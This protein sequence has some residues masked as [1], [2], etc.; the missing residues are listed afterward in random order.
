MIPM[1]SQK[2]VKSKP[3]PVLDIGYRIQVEQPNVPNSFSKKG[4]TLRCLQQIRDYVAQHFPHWTTNDVCQQLIIPLTHRDQ[5][6]F[7]DFLKKYYPLDSF[8][9]TYDPNN[10]LI[11]ETIV[12]DFLQFFTLSHDDCYGEKA[13]VYVSHAWK[14][15]FVELVEAL[16]TFFDDNQSAKLTI[17]LHYKQREAFKR[18]LRDYYEETLDFFSHVDITQSETEVKLDKFR[19]VDAAG[20]LACGVDAVNKQITQ[21]LREWVT[22]SHDALISPAVG[23]SLIKGTI[24]ENQLASYQSANYSDAVN[25]DMEDALTEY[26]HIG[27]IYFD[28]GLLVEAE[29]MFRR[30]LNGREKLLGPYHLNTVNT[31]NN[32]AILLHN[33]DRQEEAE[34]MYRRAINGSLI[35]LG[36]DHPDTLSAMNSFGKLLYNMRKLEE[37]EDMCRR[38]VNGREK[39]LGPNDVKTIGSLGNLGKVLLAL[40]QYDEAETILLKVL[41]F[42]EK[43]Y[44]L[45]DSKTYE[46]VANL[47]SCYAAEGKLENAETMYRRGIAG[48]QYLNK[49]DHQEIIDLF[50]QLGKAIYSRSSFAMIG[51]NVNPNDIF[52]SVSRDDSTGF[53]NMKSRSSDPHFRVAEQG[54]N[55]FELLE[56]TRS[57]KQGDGGPRLIVPE[58]EPVRSASVQYDRD[59]VYDDTNQN[60]KRSLD[61]KGY[62]INPLVKND[63]LGD[64]IGIEMTQY[65]PFQNQTKHNIISHPKYNDE[66]QLND[67]G[68]SSFALRDSK[69]HFVEKTQQLREQLSK[70]EDYYGW[71]H[72]KSLK[73]AHQLASCLFVQGL[74]FDALEILNKV[75]LARIT[76]L[77]ENHIDSIDIIADL[78]KVYEII[79]E[80][81]DAKEAYS[82]VLQM[83][84]K[85]FG[86]THNRTIRSS[87]I[88]CDFLF[89]IGQVEQAEE[90][91]RNALNDSIAI[92]G[93]SHISTIQHAQRLALYLNG[94]NSSSVGL[95][96]RVG[97]VEQILHLILSGF[98]QHLGNAHITTLQH[99]LPLARLLQLKGLF[100]ESEDLYRRIMIGM[101]TIFLGGATN[102][103]NLIQVLSSIAQIMEI[104]G[105]CTDAATM[106]RRVLFYKQKRLGLNHNDTLQEMMVAGKLFQ[107]LGQF[108]E[109]EKMFRTV[110]KEREKVF[111]VSLNHPDVIEAIVALA[112]LLYSADLFVE[113]EELYNKA[114]E[115]ISAQYG[116]LHL[117]VLSL[118]VKL[119]S[120]YQSNNRWKDSVLLA[121]EILESHKTLYGDTHGIVLEDTD[122]L[123]ECLSRDKQ[124][125]DGRSYAIELQSNLL[126]VRIA[127]F[128][129]SIHPD[130]CSTKQR[131][132]DL[133]QSKAPEYNSTGSVANNDEVELLSLQVLSCQLQSLTDEHPDV[134][135]TVFMVGKMYRYIQNYGLAKEHYQRALA[136]RWKIYGVNHPDTLDVVQHLAELALLTDEFDEAEDMLRKTI[137][138]RGKLFS[139]P[140]GNVNERLLSHDSA[141][142]QNK[143][144]K[145][146]FGVANADN[147]NVGHGE[148]DDVTMRN[149]TILGDILMRSGGSNKVEEAIDLFRRV[150]RFREQRFGIHD[151]DTLKA[152]SKL[153]QLLVLSNNKSEAMQV[154]IKALAG[155]AKIFGDDSLEASDINHLIGKSF[156]KDECE[157]AE[158]YMRRAVSGREKHLGK[159]H[160]D[161]IESLFALGEIV[162]SLDRLDE[163]EVILRRVLKSCQKVFGNSHVLTLTVTH[164]LALVLQRE[165]LPEEAEEM[166]EKA[167]TG[168]ELVLGMEHADLMSTL[169]CFA[170]LLQAKG[171][172]IRAEELYQRALSVRRNLFG[173]ENL[174]TLATAYAY[175]TLLQNSSRLIEAEE[176]Y[177]MVVNGRVKLLGDEDPST[178]ISYNGLA[179]VLKANN[180]MIE[181]EVYYIKAVTG[182]EQ[183]LTIEHP[184]TLSSMHQLGLVY[185]ANEKSVEALAIFQRIFHIQEKELGQTH[186]DTIVTMRNIA[187]IRQK[188]GDLEKAEQ[189]YRHIITT[190]RNQLGADHADTINGVLQ[191]GYICRDRSNIIDAEKYF[192]RALGLRE[193]SLGA[194][195]PDTIAVS[196]DLAKLLM[197]TEQLVEAEALLRQTLSLFEDWYGQSDKRTLA[198]V[199]NLANTL[200]ASDSFPEAEECY[201]RVLV[202]YEEVFGIEHE[203]TLKIVSKLASMVY[204]LGR[205]DDS[206]LLFVRLA[207]GREKVLGALH[208]DTMHSVGLCI[209]IFQIRGKNDLAYDMYW[210]QLTAQQLVYGDQSLKTLSTMF[211]FGNLL[212]LM[213][214]HEQAEEQFRAALEGKENLFSK[215]GHM[216][217]GEELDLL[218]NITSLAQT[219][220]VLKKY[221]EAEILHRRYL[222][223]MLRM[224]AKSADQRQSVLRQSVMSEVSHAGLAEEGNEEILRTLHDLASVLATKGKYKES[225]E[226]F[227]R[228]I[229]GRQDFYGPNEEET[230]KSMVGLGVLYYK[231]YHPRRFQQG[232]DFLRQAS[233]LWGE[234]DDLVSCDIYHHLGSLLF[235]KSQQISNSDNSSLI[236]DAIQF[237]KKA[238][239]SRKSLLEENHDNTL[240]TMEMLA[241]VFSS[242]PIYYDQ[243]E[244]MYSQ[245]LNIRENQSS[246]GPRSFEAVYIRNKYA[247]FLKKLEARSEES[248]KLFKQSVHF[249][250]KPDAERDPVALAMMH[251]IGVTLIMR[252]NNVEA[253]ELLSKVL[254]HREVVLGEDHIDTL[255]TLEILTSFLKENYIKNGSND[256]IYPS[257]RLEEMEKVLLKFVKAHSE[258]GDETIMGTLEIL[259]LIQEKLGRYSDAEQSYRSILKT[260]LTTLS[261]P[262]DPSSIKIMYQNILRMSVKENNRTGAI[263]VIQTMLKSHNDGIMLLSENEEFELL[264]TL[265]AMMKLLDNQYH[266]AEA[267][268]RRALVLALKIEN[269]HNKESLPSSID[270]IKCSIANILHLTNRFD[271]SS[272]LYAEALRDH[273]STPSSSSPKNTL[274]ILSALQDYGI[275]LKTMG[276][277][278]ESM[279]I[280][281][282][283]LD[284]RRLS[285]PDNIDTFLTLAALGE[286]MFDASCKK[287]LPTDDAEQMI[288][289]AING[290]VAEGGQAP[291][292]LSK[293]LGEIYISKGMY[294][295]AE[296]ILRTEIVTQ[297]GDDRMMTMIQLANVLVQVRNIAEAIN[298]IKQVIEI[299]ITSQHDKIHEIALE[300]Y[301]MLLLLQGGVAIVDEVL[302]HNLDL[303]AL[304][305]RLYGQLSAESNKSLDSLCGLYLTFGKYDDAEN[306]MSRQKQIIMGGYEKVRLLIHQSFIH[307]TRGQHTQAN[308]L[309]EEA[310][311]SSFKEYGELNIVTIHS[312]VK[313]A[314]LQTI[315]GHLPEAD[316]TYAR[317][318]KE[319]VQLSDLYQEL[320]LSHLNH[321][322]TH[323]LAIGCIDPQFE[324]MFLYG[325]P[326]K[327]RLCQSFII[328]ATIQWSAV[329]DLKGQKDDAVKVL[330]A[331][332]NEMDKPL[333][334]N[335]NRSSDDSESPTLFGLESLTVLSSLARLWSDMG[336]YDTAIPLYHRAIVS[337]SKYYGNNHHLTLAVHCELGKIF[338]TIGRWKEAEITFR[339]VLSGQETIYKSDSPVLLDTMYT[340]GIVLKHRC[341]FSA[342][343][344]LLNKSL[345][346]RKKVLGLL[347][348]HT[349]AS[350]IAVIDLL[351]ATGKQAD[352]EQVYRKSLVELE[353]IFGNDHLETLIWTHKLGLTLQTQGKYHESE[354]TLRKALTGIIQW[355]SLHPSPQMIQTKSLITSSN[356]IT[357][358]NDQPPYSEMTMSIWRSIAEVNSSLKRYSESASCYHK[359]L[360]FCEIAFGL[361]H[362]DT[363]LALQSLAM[364]LTNQTEGLMEGAEPIMKELSTIYRKLLSSHKARFGDNHPDTIQA[365]LALSALPKSV[366]SEEEFISLKEEAEESYFKLFER[367]ANDVLVD[368]LATVETLGR[369]FV[370]KGQYAK[371]EEQ[372]R[373]ALQDR[374]KLLGLKH[375]TTLTTALHLARVYMRTGDGERAEECF[376]RCY[377]G[378]LEVLGRR[379]EDSLRA[380][381]ELVSFIFRNKG[382]IKAAMILLED[383]I[384]EF[385]Q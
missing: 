315:R 123:C 77:G 178:I 335:M 209:S 247:T 265:G 18:Q 240:E 49:S 263:D 271:E 179:K 158:L 288:L 361:N 170:E 145:S 36:Q 98:E 127:K 19:I 343:E 285:H 333:M 22:R 81:E 216:T 279:N 301:C 377:F 26:V 34:E 306:I 156:E 95:V 362:P 89:K 32:L 340:F 232:E 223:G 118:K 40:G 197:L 105:R 71:Y 235:D 94:S 124:I 251:S 256:S 381:L 2:S 283:T 38:A 220:H 15:L 107:K 322:H 219:L 114:L 382:E 230:I 103:L 50:T 166:F 109:A 228:A 309:L 91:A 255:L 311:N 192:R 97:E 201:R 35:A 76:V 330:Q 139:P 349:K 261:T 154:F 144:Y 222:G 203:E 110:L 241:N 182:N 28:Q 3:K 250:T 152:M 63:A 307:V 368:P 295:D 148:L 113:S 246:Y 224:Q 30:A 79:G 319:R 375:P 108:F 210:K 54:H 138:A 205:L 337:Y 1:L 327:N 243:A 258:K 202:G 357:S 177:R 238:L 20:R 227:Q 339:A 338:F 215:S 16:E 173:E 155:T 217:T 195:H 185:K 200:H 150:V 358:S 262:T 129:S 341:S 379:H 172:I 164:T 369:F 303:L 286:V 60:A 70:S 367:N 130:V 174:D 380:L 90:I 294:V 51:G 245:I 92:F 313:L 323:S 143:E 181:A 372:F 137:D 254:K 146:G 24:K 160:A 161:T 239:H 43:M 352:I 366:I 364:V 356:V 189:L 282:V 297:S 328:S 383:N 180:K 64:P 69:T 300:Q 264:C 316:A 68:D 274:V 284:R 8:L 188:I 52:H 198:V 45:N 175:G 312:L 33:Q 82:K 56:G 27:R 275:L 229:H 122:R 165:D 78:G 252:K 272:L 37:A 298:T 204:I 167:K 225:E 6:S 208:P 100:E 317:A 199:Y 59:P 334:Q 370:L 221:N 371:A 57:K 25:R 176:M 169:H 153:G 242:A 65:V 234:S 147:L 23:Q 11:S 39:I 193:L 207:S 231:Q 48:K 270:A 115:R 292:T 184:Y 80:F 190:C 140:V 266:E 277:I 302:Q 191:L 360:M 344:E 268:L 336:A 132:I 163:A 318:L 308:D 101:E 326:I 259:A 136:G 84:E 62:E 363:A 280:L 85:V 151:P 53:E 61:E 75:Q 99:A 10:N 55:L 269:P 332:L 29:E 42:R 162:Y 348:P 314:E 41:S 196:F 281:Q 384:I 290:I 119:L 296:S 186:L 347:H 72:P 278:E 218:A 17:Q 310:V 168:R 378:R 385:E 331:V 211:Q 305:D 365:K 93:E 112:D 13:T 21:L 14:Y 134:L 289:T 66:F 12:R 293:K 237:L 96:E 126:E 31:I 253:E 329:L 376:R 159:E 212:K 120:I 373:R 88:Y 5:C 260:S 7:D 73:C 276:N 67:I 213:G 121:A 46:S 214:R 324:L 244:V 273:I 287:A 350:L 183:M 304:R 58:V 86:V 226:L 187:E 133:Y 321:Y 116:S 320:E 291:S 353:A 135:E 359:A 248:E 351:D 355:E 47:G 249:H 346:G 354:I 141:L 142:N 87:D 149:M 236:E 117:F 125:D 128:N 374:E 9:D 233:E 206:E 194:T 131:L 74:F 106:I 157:E 4:V 257:N 171:N 299:A 325:L 345:N 44:G 104:R 111:S 342:A 83:N 102:D 267:A